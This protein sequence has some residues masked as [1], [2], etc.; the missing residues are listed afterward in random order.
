[1]D[2]LST[3]EL[4]PDATADDAKAAYRRLAKRHHPDLNP[5]DPLAAGKFAAIREAYEAFSRGEH[6]AQ[7]VPAS[8][9]PS[10]AA[11][12]RRPLG[13]AC[14][15]PLRGALVGMPF[16]SPVSARVTCRSCRGSG[17]A[18]CPACAIPGNPFKRMRPWVRCPVC[19][20]SGPAPVP[21]LCPACGGSAEI[22]VQGALSKPV[23]AGSHEG[24]LVSVVADGREH[25][26][27]LAIQTPAGA[28]RTG[29]D[30]EIGHGVNP[31]TLAAGFSSSLTA[32]DGWNA[33]F[34]VPPGARIGHVV[35]LEG[36]GIP[37]AAA[38]RGSLNIR[39]QDRRRR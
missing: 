9:R 23:P 20:A 37:Y 31:G 8:S 30:L 25:E 38:E 6:L 18:D 29:A 39:L 7:A 3:L 5:G 16:G 1:M 21:V 36:R 33:R 27:P 12:R 4:G 14:L 11:V 26:L 32:P 10:P 24:C 15:V 22:L 17:D 35:T 19:G 2:P 13:L 28:I 34:T